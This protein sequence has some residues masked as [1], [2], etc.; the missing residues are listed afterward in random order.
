[1]RDSTSY[2]SNRRNMWHF[3]PKKERGNWLSLYPRD[4]IHR[5]ISPARK[6]YFD[7]FNYPDKTK[8]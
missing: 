7:V 3:L 4:A 2:R 8:G 1:M 5:R 6:K